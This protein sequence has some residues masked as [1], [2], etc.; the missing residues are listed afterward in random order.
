MRAWALFAWAGVTVLFAVFFLVLGY[1]RGLAASVLSV[2]V[3][4]DFQRLAFQPGGSFN[5]YFGWYNPL[6]YVGA[7][8]LILLLPA[9]VRRSPSWRG[10]A[11]GT[12]IG[13]LWGL[14]SYL[15]QENLA[16]G[17]VGALAAAVLLLFSGTAPWR[18]VG[19]ALAAA[20]AGFLLIWTPVLAFYA[21]H[22]QLAGFRQQ[23]FLFPEAVA[24]GANDTP[25]GG[26]THAPTPDSHMFYVLPFVLAGLA[27]LTVVQV[28]PLRIATPWSRERALLVM[29]V[30]ATTVMYEGALLR[31]DPPHL[32]GAE[33]MVPA[34]VIVTATVLPGLL[35][36]QRR[37]VAALTAVALIAASE[38]LLPRAA[39]T[40]A[41]VR[42]WAEAPY[43]DRQRLAA[44]PCPRRA[45]DVGGPSNRCRARRRRTVLRGAAR[46]DA[47]IHPADG[48]DSYGRRHPH[49]LCRRFPRFVPR[50][51][52][53]RGRSD[54][55]TGLVRQV[56]QH[57][58]KARA[59]G[60][61]GRLPHEG[62]ADGTCTPH[63]FIQSA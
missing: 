48:A 21:A 1:A 62:R 15:A 18:A 36:V 46:V 35:G 3:Y 28:R 19:S 51:C 24:T 2:L 61:H 29:S 39:L 59:E 30:L 49:G 9:V 44:A 43:L 41:N 57:R 14:T 38:V 12:A 45:R 25:W 13:A 26:F 42:S 27:L 63:L 34:L 58:D 50:H 10:A 8:A 40:R 5:G 47:G 52:L 16:A 23:F 6:R 60:I 20:L 56:Q 31:S 32:T 55:R 7:I 37:V 33:L 11:G 4:P 17:A 53:L 22:G 54:A